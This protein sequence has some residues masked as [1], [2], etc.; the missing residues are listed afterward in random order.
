MT[1]TEDQLQQFISKFKDKIPTEV[2][3][4]KITPEQALLDIET[5]RATRSP[6]ERSIDIPAGE[7]IAPEKF[8]ELAGRL[9]GRERIPDTLPTLQVPTPIRAKIYGLDVEEP[10]FPTPTEEVLGFGGGVLE[11]VPEQATEAIKDIPSDVQEGYEAIKTKL[12]DRGK[13]IG[14]AVYDLFQNPIRNAEKSFQTVA[15]NTLLSFTDVIGEVFATGAKILTPPDVE[16]ALGLISDEGA[17]AIMNTETVQEVADGVS[18]IWNALPGRTKENLKTSGAVGL[19]IA[20]VLGL[21]SVSAIK[22]SLASKFKKFTKTSPRPKTPKETAGVGDPKAGILK[23]VVNTVGVGLDDADEFISNVTKKILLSTDEGATAMVRRAIKPTKGLTKKT[24]ESVDDAIES[25]N[26]YLVSVG[27]IPEDIVSYR[28]ILKDELKIFW[29]TRIKSKLDA[30]D[31]QIDLTGIAAKLRE[32]ANSPAV[33]KGSKTSSDNLLELAD[34]LEGVV[35]KSDGT[36]EKNP[37]LDILDAEDLKQVV[38]DLA[39]FDEVGKSKIMNT[40]LKEVSKFIGDAQD[41]VLSKVPKEFAN[42]KKLWGKM[43]ETFDHVN[44]RANV[45]QRQAPVGLQEGLTRA[46]GA[47]KTLTGIAKGRPSEAVGGVAQIALGRGAQFINDPDF[48]IRAAFERLL[49]RPLDEVNK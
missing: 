4:P 22:K 12:G 5:E 15:Q 44:H 41:A 10:E 24:L 46:E 38:N 21:G 36:I 11:G 3:S 9:S 28:D 40:A 39:N 48:M 18:E 47:A 16:K 7:G 26:N 42:D 35:K 19:F 14:G 37:T 6:I 23:K 34:R 13:K 29:D 17:E 49:K 25:T 45:V 2:E 33:I 1:I 32:R 20:D 43:R 31:A 27:K 8:A 30:S